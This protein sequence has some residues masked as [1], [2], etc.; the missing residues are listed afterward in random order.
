MVGLGLL[1]AIPESEIVAGADPN[2]ANG[3]GIKG[4]ANYVW[5]AVTQTRQLGRFGWKANTASILTQVATAFNQDMGITS[6]VL[7][8]ESSFGQSQY[9]GL[10]DDPELPDSLLNSVK[11]YAQTLAVPARR[12]TTDVTVKRGEALFISMKCVN[13]H[14]QTFTTGV[15]V[16]RPYLS[17]QV[18]HPYTDMLVHDMGPGLADNRPDFLAGGTEWRTAPLWGLGLYTTVNSPGYFLHDGRARTITEAI[19]WHGGEAEQSKTTFSN[20]S[21]TDRAAVLKFLQSL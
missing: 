2:D 15:D 10:S 7:P 6:S 14:K 20:L 3:D 5:D 16:S 8:V 12:N 18:I 4:H 1:E 17:N 19:M 21:S 13:C 9:D 11:F